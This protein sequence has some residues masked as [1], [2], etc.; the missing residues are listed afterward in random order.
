MS[1]GNTQSNAN[2]SAGNKLAGL[3]LNNLHKMGM[4]F[5]QQLIRS[6]RLGLG[7]DEPSSDANVKTEEFL[8]AKVIAADFV[9]LPV[10]TVEEMGNFKLESEDPPS[11]DGPPHPDGF[12]R[13][14]PTPLSGD[15]ISKYAW[16]A[17]IVELPW[18]LHEAT[19]IELVAAILNR[20][21]VHVLNGSI[22]YPMDLWM[23]LLSR[24]GGGRSTI[25]NSAK[26]L[27]KEAGYDKNLVQNSFW[28]SAPA[29]QEALSNSTEGQLYFWGE[30]ATV[31]K[32]FDTAL[33]MAAKEW[34]TDLYDNPAIPAAKVYRSGKK[35]SGTKPIVF[36]H[37]PRINILAASSEAWFYD[38]LSDSDSFGGWLPRWVFVTAGENQRTVARPIPY[39]AAMRSE[40]AQQLK[41]IGRLKG[42]AHIPEEIL[43]DYDQWYAA[44]QERFKSHARRD[45]AEPYFGR[46]RGTVL[47]LAVIYEASSMSIDGNEKTINVSWQSWNRAKQKCAEWSANLFEMLKTGMSA[48]GQWQKKFIDF[49]GKSGEKGVPQNA[50]TRAF[51]TVDP[52]IRETNFDTLVKSGQIH[53]F[54]LKTGGKPALMLVLEE[55]C[56]GRCGNCE[57]TRDG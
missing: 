44:E 31:L 3:L 30:L 27:L 41:R 37:S 19:A 39:D 56:K 23:A 51:Q 46:Y 16:W 43:R 5:I 20:N 38:H 1:Y 2:H 12:H 35:K 40:L 22:W 49:I 15:F 24:S 26:D 13:F 11:T 8:P 48:T 4:G 33:F 18:V 10:N 45:L 54:K 34:F 9:S 29:M 21:G 53:T 47:K 55:D 32:T 50:F 52:R 36:D 28:G 14:A 6:N 42:P 25:L 57:G 17:D 7:T